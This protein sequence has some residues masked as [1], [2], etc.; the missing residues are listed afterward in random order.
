MPVDPGGRL[1]PDPA[2]LAPVLVT[3]PPRRL[4]LADV[5]DVER[6]RARHA[7]DR[8]LDLALECG[9]RSGLGEAAAEA[10]LPAIREKLKALGI[11]T[12]TPNI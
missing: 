4:P 11:A 1:E 5:G 10:A 7:A 9:L 8:Q 6:N 12:T 3:V 2:H